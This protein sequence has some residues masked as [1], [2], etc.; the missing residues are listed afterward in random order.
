MNEASDIFDA[1]QVD[2]SVP[3]D[4]AYVSTL[5]SCAASIGARCDLTIDT[6]EDLRLAVSE[7]CGIL[8]S[9]AERP[10]CLHARFVVT[11]LCLKFEAKISIPGV[12]NSEPFDRSGLGWVILT[13]LVSELDAHVDGDSSG[14]S[15]SVR[16]EAIS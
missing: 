15:F 5:R 9:L 14:I 8:L 16:R 3:A 1:E 11:N 6:I 2:I 13:A 12:Q 10:S 7:A 4:A